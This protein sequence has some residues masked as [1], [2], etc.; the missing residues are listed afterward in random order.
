MKAA[1]PGWE[2]HRIARRVDGWIIP[3]N[4]DCIPAAV[5]AMIVEAMP[6]PGDRDA[7]AIIR[8]RMMVRQR[9]YERKKKVR[10]AR[11]R[12]FDRMKQARHE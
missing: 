2:P 7:I 12:M 10:I 8:G 6:Q 11:Q 3:P 1:P 5:A 9:V 4:E